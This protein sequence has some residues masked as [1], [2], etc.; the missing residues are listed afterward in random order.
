MTGRADRAKKIFEKMKDLNIIWCAPNG[1]RISSIDEEMIILMKESG[2]YRLTYALESGD[3]ELRN[4]HI[5]KPY[6]NDNIKRIVRLTQK[7]KIGLHTFWII[8]FPYETKE[9]MWKTYRFAIELNSDSAS[10]CLATPMIGTQLL[11][12]CEENN[13]LREGFDL[14]TSHYLQANIINPNIGFT[15]LESL[16]NQFNS[17]YN[18]R[19]LWRNPV[20]FFKKYGKSIRD[21]PKG[22]LNI[23]KKFA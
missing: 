16:V 2:C 10:F 15:E 7:H 18:R 21:N 23:F 8:G 22:I 5:N 17:S 3:E 19:L 20:K 13:L 12:T 4:N 1:V 14:R 11:T 9:Q 6:K